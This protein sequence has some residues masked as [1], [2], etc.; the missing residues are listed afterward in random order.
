MA[1]VGLGLEEDW[2]LFVA[3]LEASDQVC[4]SDIFGRGWVGESGVR[5]AW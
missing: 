5:A 4:T 3:W 1:L 2:S